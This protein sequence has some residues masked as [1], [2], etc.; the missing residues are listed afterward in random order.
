MSTHIVGA[1]STSHVLQWDQGQKEKLTRV[2]DSDNNNY[3][4][5]QLKRHDRC[6]S[7]QIMFMVGL[8]KNEL[9]KSTST[10]ISSTVVC[11]VSLK[12][13]LIKYHNSSFPEWTLIRLY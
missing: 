7:K 12:T 13:T 2:I 5:T 1:D 8:S 3:G 10:S 4:R 11:L 6:T 9:L